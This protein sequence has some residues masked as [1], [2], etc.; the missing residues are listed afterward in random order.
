M[1]R[2]LARLCRIPAQSNSTGFKVEGVWFLRKFRFV[3]NCLSVIMPEEA[4]TL[5]CPTPTD[6]MEWLK[7]LQ[8]AIRQSLKVNGE[9]ETP[10]NERNGQSTTPP[11]VRSATYTFTKLAHLKDVTYTGRQIV[12]QKSREEFDSVQF[13]FLLIRS[14]ALWENARRRPTLLAGRPDISRQFPSERS[15]RLRLHGITGSE[16]NGLRGDLEGWQN[17]WLRHSQVLDDIPLIFNGQ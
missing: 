5:T 10:S 4:L 6:K 15:V 9:A 13:C 11:L 17:E 2:T 3:K 7:A 12:D 8:T 14:L 1:G 16:W